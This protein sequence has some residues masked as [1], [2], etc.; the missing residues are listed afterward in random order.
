MPECDFVASQFTGDVKY[1]FSSHPGAQETGIFT[2][3]RAVRP[4][5]IIRMHY[6]QGQTD[7]FDPL[8]EVIGKSVGKAGI[9]I[10]RKQLIANG[11][12]GKAL[13]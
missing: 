12:P 3:I 1:F 8:M 2:I 9:D 5:A 7:G 10:D 11:Y 6:P 4:N 13:I